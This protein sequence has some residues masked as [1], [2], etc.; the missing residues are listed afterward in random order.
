MFLAPF[1]EASVRKH[2][3]VPSG[4]GVGGKVPFPRTRSNTPTQRV[5]GFLEVSIRRHEIVFSG[6]E[7]GGR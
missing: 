5:D 6:S 3:L 2:E 4:R 7:S 1:F